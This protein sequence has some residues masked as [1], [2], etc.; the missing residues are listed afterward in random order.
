MSAP[1]E[2]LSA[3]VAPFTVMMCVS[4]AR[5]GPAL[6]TLAS[7]LLGRRGEPAKLIALHLFH[8]TDRPS[9]ELRRQGEKERHGPL[10]PLLTR[11]EELMLEV[12]PLSFVSAE[13]AEDIRRAAEAKQASVLL[14]GAHKPLL[15]EGSLGGMVSA[16]AAESYCPVGVLIDRGLRSVNKV[17]VAYA[18]GPEDLVALELARRISRAPGVEFTLLHV[19]SPSNRDRGKG[20][21]QIAKALRTP[22][23]GRIMPNE[24]LN[25]PDAEASGG[26]LR[27]RIVE[28][29]SPPDAVLEESLRD[30]DLVV[31]GMHARW[32]LDGGISLRR[33]RV[34]TE[35]RVSIL[36]VH[37]P[38]AP[39]TSAVARAERG[40][41]TASYAPRELTE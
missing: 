36:A 2:P 10:A 21:V 12:R 1:A 20:R 26:A 39:V 27:V 35:S 16:V 30:Y 24:L 9:V 29:P 34:L 32:G 41:V 33:Q 3:Q 23:P 13:P 37:P 22:V 8:P 17:L 31:L 5:V 15:M 4:D 25:V 19:A 40:H 7:A 28:H 11:A 38:V 18:G 6:A 14:L